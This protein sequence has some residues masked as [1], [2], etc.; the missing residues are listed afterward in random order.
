MVF[1]ASSG[2][3]NSSVSLNECL[4]SGPS[5]TPLLFGVLVRFRAHNYI[6]IAD[7]EKAFLQIDLATKHRN[8]VR[9]LWFKDIHN[10]DEEFDL[11]VLVNQLTC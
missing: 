3:T 7:I 4:F 6:V 5:L 2:S 9:F 10:I 11:N 8:Y 1:D